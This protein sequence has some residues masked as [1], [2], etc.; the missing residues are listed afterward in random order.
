MK[1]ILIL[2]LDD[3]CG[4]DNLSPITAN[5]VIADGMIAAGSTQPNLLSKIRH[6]DKT[7]VC[8]DFTHYKPNILSRN[9]SPDHLLQLEKVHSLCEIVAPV[10]GRMGLSGCGNISKPDSE[11]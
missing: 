1:V 6:V 4:L 3:N 8:K 7:I 9:P 2:D 5:E 10:A 11:Q